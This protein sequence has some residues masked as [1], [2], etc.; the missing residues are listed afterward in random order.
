MP[1]SVCLVSC[2]VPWVLARNAYGDGHA[3]Q[4]PGRQQGE[5]EVDEGPI[6]WADLYRHKQR[7]AK[8]DEPAKPVFDRLARDPTSLLEGQLMA[9]PTPGVNRALL[10][11]AANLQGLAREHPVHLELGK[12]ELN[13]AT[14]AAYWR[15]V[16]L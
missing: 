13:H 5:A 3:E 2:L 10:P 11:A 1:S 12:E 6:R 16:R 14:H 9:K 8:G 4:S 15:V 7:G